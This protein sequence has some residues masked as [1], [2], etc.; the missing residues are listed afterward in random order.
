MIMG[1]MT[2]YLPRNLARWRTTLAAV[3]IVSA[4]TS[5]FPAFAQS[6]VIARDMDINSL[7]I[8]RSWCDACVIYNSAVYESLLTLDEVVL[9]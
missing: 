8:H 3:A 9:Q 2:R 6:L 1:N 5:A 4:A 7:D